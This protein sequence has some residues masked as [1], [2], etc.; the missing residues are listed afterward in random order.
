[1]TEVNNA[2][3]LSVL[4][5]E[6][7]ADLYTADEPFGM[8]TIEFNR[9]KI[10]DLLQYLYDH[11]L[12]KMQFLTD[13]CG[14]HYPQQQD[15]ELGVIYH[16]HS[17]QNNIRLRIKCFMPKAEPNIPTVSKLFNSANWQERETYDF[18]GINFTG[19]PNLKRIL[20][21]DEMDYFPMLKEY[22]LEDQ[23]RT[24]KDDRYF[25]R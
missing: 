21:V 16:V 8:L 20:N 7:A 18:Y 2:Y 19:H 3:L 12:I 25:G 15:R 23:S 1:M 11:P 4:Q 17:L 24:D 9:S 14:I 5:E 13:V 22:P 6:F 10:A